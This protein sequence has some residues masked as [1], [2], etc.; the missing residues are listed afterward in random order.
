MTV[1]IEEQI[2]CVRRE[3][4]YR[5]YVYPKQVEKG[6]MD[7]LRADK[8]INAM[9]AVLETLLKIAPTTGLFA[10][11]NDGDSSAKGV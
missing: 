9:A 2:K 4:N 6:K 7:Q 5:K 10:N 1:D 3:L 11:V 8:E